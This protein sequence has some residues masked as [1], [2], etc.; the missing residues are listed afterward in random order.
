MKLSNFYPSEYLDN[1][2]YQD[3]Y[4]HNGSADTS[5]TQEFTQNREL[6]SL[7]NLQESLIKK[8]QYKKISIWAKVKIVHNSSE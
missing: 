7:F 2:L 3:C 6:N 5:Q 4:I 8:A 1:C